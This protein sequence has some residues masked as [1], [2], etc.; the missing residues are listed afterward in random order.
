ML[1]FKVKKLIEIMQTTQIADEEI[2]DDTEYLSKKLE[3]LVNDVSSFDEYAAE[4]ASGRL[5]WSPVHK[6][7]K[8]WRENAARLNENNFYLVKLVFIFLPLF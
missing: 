6:S 5:S 4:V 7:D 8:F 3:L 2:R 1:Q